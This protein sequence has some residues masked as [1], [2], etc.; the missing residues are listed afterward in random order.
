ML[1][2]FFAFFAQFSGRV[3]TLMRTDVMILMA[4]IAITILVQSLD[5]VRFA[6]RQGFTADDVIVAAD[7]MADETS[8]AR[9]LLLSDPVERARILRRKRLAIFGGAAGGAF[10]PVV[11]RSVIQ[12]VAGQR[13]I[14]TVGLLLLLAMT[15][16]FGIS[17]AFW[18]ARPVR[19][20]LA[21]R[22]ARR[23][24]RSSLGR[25]L[26]A[27]AERRYALEMKR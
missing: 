1:A 15:V 16:L 14:S 18:Q 6:V 4:T 20:T 11:A 25:A 3:N 26:F 19:V 23:I 2:A 12:E 21:Q 8:R 27:R 17:I 9:D 22:A 24:W 10:I 5:R 7:A 13:V